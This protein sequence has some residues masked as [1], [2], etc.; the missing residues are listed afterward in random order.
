MAK[1]FTDVRTTQD[2]F[3]EIHDLA[4][5]GITT[6]WPDGTF[7]PLAEVQRVAVVAFLYRAFGSPSFTPPVR[8]PFRDMSPSSMFYKETAWAAAKGIVQGWTDG[9]FRPTA[10]IQ[11]A[12]IAA[13]LMR[14][15]GGTGQ[16]AR[17]PFRDVPASHQ[18]AK[19]IGWAA[20]NGITRGWSDGTFRPWEPTNRDAMAA[21]MTRWLTLTGR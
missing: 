19:E 4:A 21:F 3:L 9:T 11:R 10:P 7:R 18:F 1:K 8:S 20:N 13:M 6:G 5:K 14:A 16:T 15:A 17:T 12:A 2:F